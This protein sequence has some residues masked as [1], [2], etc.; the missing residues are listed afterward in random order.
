M[1]SHPKNVHRQH[2]ADLWTVPCVRLISFI[3]Y[4]QCSCA[5]H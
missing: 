1:L 5:V 3:L 2:K 4:C